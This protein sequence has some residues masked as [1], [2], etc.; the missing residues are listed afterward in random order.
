[1]LL[2]DTAGHIRGVYNGTLALEMDRLI[3][4]IRTLKREDVY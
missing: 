3:A 4:D 1:V 2:I